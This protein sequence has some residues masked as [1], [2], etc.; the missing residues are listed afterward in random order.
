MN[1]VALAKDFLAD[2]KEYNNNTKATYFIKTM[3]DWKDEIKKID[4][5]TKANVYNIL[6][7]TMKA[8]AKEENYEEAKIVKQASELFLEYY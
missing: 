1:P 2:F 8:Q 7:A 5:V 3:Q 4:D 6:T